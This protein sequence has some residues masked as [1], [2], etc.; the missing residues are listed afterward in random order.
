MEQRINVIALGV[1]DVEEA[2]K[3][4]E[5]LGWKRTKINNPIGQLVAVFFELNHN[6]VFLG[7]IPVDALI[8][9]AGLTDLKWDHHSY[10]TG[11]TLEYN[12]STKDEVSSVIEQ[13]RQAGA[14][15][16]SEPSK[17]EWGGYSGY[18]KDPNGHLWGIVYNPHPE[19]P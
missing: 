12:V 3:F 15:I 11:K 13:A 6:S 19:L 2:A 1:E 4:Y 7:L 8:K 14:T 17:R 18:F 9:E 16:T 10:Q 5:S